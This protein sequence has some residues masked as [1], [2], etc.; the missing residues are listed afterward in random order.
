MILPKSGLGEK[1]HWMMSESIRFFLPRTTC[2]TRDSSIIMELLQRPA[3]ATKSY[4]QFLP[5]QLPSAIWDVKLPMYKIFK[6]QVTSPQYLLIEHGRCIFITTFL[7][8]TRI[9]F[10]KIQQFR[11]YVHPIFTLL[12][13]TRLLPHLVPNPRLCSQADYWCCTTPASVAWKTPAIFPN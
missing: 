1:V 4:N 11:I 6:Q 9:C 10:V 7:A 13:L 3:S 8:L 12:T 2:I 5:A